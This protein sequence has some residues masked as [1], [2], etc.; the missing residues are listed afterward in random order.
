MMMMM[1]TETF[2]RVFKKTV[3]ILVR[4]ETTKFYEIYKILSF[5]YLHID[6][7]SQVFLRISY[8]MLEV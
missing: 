7:I 4:K 2:L 8:V 5:F 1:K 3:I 6:L